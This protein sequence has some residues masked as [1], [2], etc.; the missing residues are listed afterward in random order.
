MVNKTKKTFKEWVAISKE[1]LEKLLEEPKEKQNEK[2]VFR[3]LLSLRTHLMSAEIK[4]RPKSC[5][6]D[7]LQGY[8]L[9][10][11]NNGKGFTQLEVLKIKSSDK[12]PK[13]L[14]SDFEKSYSAWQ[15]KNLA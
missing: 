13:T 11:F 1:K 12:F 3:E 8:Q 7:S 15:D 14:A 6:W 2:I 4:S 10:R 5:S 9:E